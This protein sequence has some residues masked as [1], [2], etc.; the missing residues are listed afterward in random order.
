M[1]ISVISLQLIPSTYSKWLINREQRAADPSTVPTV[2]CSHY[3][4]HNPA[5][6]KTSRCTLIIVTRWRAMA[7]NW[8]W[9]S[10]DKAVG[11]KTRQLIRKSAHLHPAPDYKESSADLF[12]QSIR[13]WGNGGQRFSRFRSLSVISF[14]WM[15]VFEDDIFPL[16]VFTL[17]NKTHFKAVN[18]P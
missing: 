6:T 1:N 15:F 7:R 13:R 5:S 2:V 3:V 12:L 16:P 4:V 17:E 10:A 8:E 9:Q 11:A 14:R 18:S